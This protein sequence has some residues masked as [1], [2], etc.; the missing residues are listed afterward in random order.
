MKNLMLILI[1]VSTAG[2]AQSTRTQTHEQAS[3]AFA[4]LNFFYKGR[5]M[6]ISPDMIKLYEVMSKAGIG[7]NDQG[8]IASRWGLLFRENKAVGIFNEPYEGMDVGVL[9]CVACHSGKAA[10]EYIIGLGNK[11]IDVGQIGKDASLGMKI[12]GAAPRKNPKFKELHAR[13]M[14]FTSGL[15]QKEV[16]NLTQGLVPTSLIRS[17]FYEQQGKTLPKNFPRGQVKVPHMWGYGEKRKTGSFWDGEGNGE[18]GGWGIA[19]ELYAGQTVENVREYFEK[20]HHAEN[21]LGDLLPPKYPFQID[22]LKAKRGEQVYQQ[23][24]MGCHG[25][26]E[27][28]LNGDPIFESPKHIPLT[29]V[30]TDPDRLKALTEE[31]YHLIEINPLNDVIQ[32][33]RKPTPGYV[34]QKL[35]GVWS[36]FPYLHNGSVPTIY[37]LLLPPDQRPKLFSLK[38]SGEKER[39]DETKM[40]LTQEKISNFERKSRR[41]YDVS[42]DGQSNQGHYFDKFKTLT[43]AERLALIEYLKTL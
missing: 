12:W 5:G 38:N 18:L 36:R 9:G 26:H 21:Y 31:L 20:V 11:N 43:E 19:V 22:R 14:K 15:A 2:F 41:I 25:S 33:V 17:W 42:R 23:T 27:R 13:S 24:C 37:D 8:M 40:G 16:S 32:S 34:A 3:K 6:A 7:M 35:W 39:F 10:G 1:L 4:E 30:K 29:V 28:D